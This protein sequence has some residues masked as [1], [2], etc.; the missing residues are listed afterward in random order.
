MR[1]PVFSSLGTLRLT[2][3][4]HLY[5][6]VLLSPL[7][8]LFAITGIFFNHAWNPLGAGQREPVRTRGLRVQ[9]R[10]N[11]QGLVQARDILRQLG[12]EGEINFVTRSRTALTIPVMLPGK[13][14]EVRVNLRDSTADITERGTGIGGALLYLHASPGQHNANIR[15]NW[16]YTRLWGFVAD[17]AVYLILFLSASGILLW[18][19]A[20][21]ERRTGLVM[22]GLGSLSLALIL[23]AVL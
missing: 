11:Q 19:G 20:K 12:V 6:G 4:L 22:I 18:T 15:G 5:T 13:Q 14:I 10:E 23:V 7:V 1:R 9:V 3:N 17:G 21:A 2:R 8:V 16:I